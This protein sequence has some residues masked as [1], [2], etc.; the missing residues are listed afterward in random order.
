MV[1]QL[2][3]SPT[4]PVLALHHKITSMGTAAGGVAA[5]ELDG[6]HAVDGLVRRIRV[7]SAD[8]SRRCETAAVRCAST[9]VDADRGLSSLP[10][11]WRSE[12]RTLSRSGRGLCIAG[13]EVCEI[14][15]RWAKHC[16]GPTRILGGGP[17]S[18]RALSEPTRVAVRTGIESADRVPLR[19]FR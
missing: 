4:C 11:R 16:P 18:G 6:K 1:Q 15:I 7:G 19:R 5:R 8:P 14:G 9:P 12:L 10:P 13:G 17:P 2:V 3:L